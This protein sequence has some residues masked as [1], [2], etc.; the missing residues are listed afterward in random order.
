MKKLKEFASG[1]VLTAED[2]NE[3]LNPSVPDDADVY[4]TGWV[5]LSLLNGWQ[6]SG[7]LVPQYRRIGLQVF[8]RGRATGGD[9][10]STVAELPSSARPPQT[11]VF[12]V[13]DGTALDTTLVTVSSLGTISPAAASPANQPNFGQITFVA[14]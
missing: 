12:V 13:R 8:L 6:A 7:S 10:G 9:P 14:D 11:T 1:E 4:D 2:V 5:N 3:Y